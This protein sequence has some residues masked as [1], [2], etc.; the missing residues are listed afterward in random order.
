MRTRLNIFFVVI[1]TL[2]FATLAAAASPA[3]APQSTSQSGVT[4]SI[5][6]RTLS[7][8]TWDFEVSFNTHSQELKDDLEKTAVL[9]AD[10]GAPQAPVKWQGAPPGGH[11]RSGTL[12]FKAVSPMPAVIELRIPRQGE[13]NP[14]SFRWQLK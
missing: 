10:G 6:P 14:R 3:L 12:Q 1:A 2:L 5:T 11:H 4:V 8:T 13:A 7:G 9:I